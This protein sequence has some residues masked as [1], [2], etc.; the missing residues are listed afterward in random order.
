VRFRL[1]LVL[2][3]LPLA[4]PAGFA[5]LAAQEPADPERP[6]YVQQR[7]FRIPFKA[8]QSHGRVIE[9]RL[10]H[11]YNGEGWVFSGKASPAHDGFQ[12]TADRD[13]SVA[14][15][16]QAV[17]E[18]NVLDPPT[19]QLKTD[20]R[21]VIDTDK[22]RAILRP[23]VVQGGAAGVEWEVTDENLNPNSIRLEYRWPDQ[24]AWLPLDRDVAFRPRDSR[25]WELKP[26]QKLEVRL[27]A[28]DLAKNEI[29]TP[30]VWT[31]PDPNNARFP[32]PLKEP[33]TNVGSSRPA[34]HHVSSKRV[35]LEYDVKVGPSGL[36]KVELWYTTNGVEWKLYNPGGTDAGGD[37]KLPLDVGLGQPAAGADEPKGDKRSLVFDAKEDGLYGFIIIARNRVGRGPEA[38]KRGDPAQVQVVVDTTKPAV[39]LL[40]VKVRS[41]GERGG[42]VVEIAWD[43]RD[44]NMAPQPITLEYAKSDDPA[45]WQLIA[46][47][48][49]NSGRF[50]WTVGTGPGD[51]YQFLVRVRCIDR[52]GNEGEAK[53]DHPVIVDLTVPSV[54]IKNVAPGGR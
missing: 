44:A 43:A 49:E 48:L 13:G 3:A 8:D 6:T 5:H 33:Q 35:R 39:K 47:K 22:P 53:S 34:L 24:Q 12:F 4:R 31:P 18:G 7:S 14:F 21:V 17:K 29:V 1:A 32:D 38:P 50:T 36:E 11:S 2:L 20:L 16:V 10:Y 26:G 15:A 51:P 45:Q 42:A 27:R 46:D 25:S 40:D 23:V 9:L 28:M 41:N 52:A 54:E 30:A 37:E 19:D